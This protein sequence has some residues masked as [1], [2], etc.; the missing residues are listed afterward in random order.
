MGIQTSPLCIIRIYIYIYIYIGICSFGVGILEFS[1]DLLPSWVVSK[2]GP[3]PMDFAC[4][5]C[6]DG[7]SAVR[8]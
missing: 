1:L 3:D 2:Q 6:S 8:G 5:L 7:G 4:L